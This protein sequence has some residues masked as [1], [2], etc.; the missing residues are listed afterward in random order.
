MFAGAND[1][2]S[3]LYVVGRGGTDPHKAAGQHIHPINGQ[4]MSL[5]R[6]VKNPQ[7]E[8]PPYSVKKT[9]GDAH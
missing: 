4:G 5:R 9:G 7:K 3:K 2:K 1:S 6:Q 8:N